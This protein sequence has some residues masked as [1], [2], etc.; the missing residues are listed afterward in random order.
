[1]NLESEIVSF[2]HKLERRQDAAYDL[3][4]WLPSYKKAQACLGDYAVNVR[5]DMALI[6]QEALQFIADKCSPCQE[7]LDNPEFIYSCPC[8]G[9]CPKQDS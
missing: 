7:D 1:M 6:M 9:I 2:A 4:T 8:Y 5:P 3:W